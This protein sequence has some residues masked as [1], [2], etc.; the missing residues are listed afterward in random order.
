MSSNLNVKHLYCSRG[1]LVSSIY[2]Q[3][4][5]PNLVSMALCDPILGGIPVSHSVTS[6]LMKPFQVNLC[7]WQN[8]YFLTPSLPVRRIHSIQG[9]ISSH[10]WHLC[11]TLHSPRDLS[12]KSCSYHMSLPS[13]QPMQRYPDKKWLIKDIVRLLWK[14]TPNTGA[15]PPCLLLSMPSYPYWKCSESRTGY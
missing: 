14:S 13:V 3:H 4:L 8:G 5:Y 2:H 15:K 6:C 12:L 7:L 1:C 11:A 9:R 10:L